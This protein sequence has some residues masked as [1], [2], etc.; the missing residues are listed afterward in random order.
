MNARV[1]LTLL[2]IALMLIALGLVWAPLVT[3]LE[4]D[5]CLDAGGS[6]DYAQRVCDFQNAHPYEPKDNTL[7]LQAAAVLAVIGVAVTIVGR[8]RRTK[9]SK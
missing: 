8:Y 2:G 4:I 9:E 6:F 3:S 5:G 1:T 7:R